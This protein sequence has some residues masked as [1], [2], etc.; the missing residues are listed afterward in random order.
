MRIKY[1]LNLRSYLA[2]NHPDKR[3]SDI[4]NFSR[5]I[6]RIRYLELSEEIHWFIERNT[7]LSIKK[8][9]NISTRKFSLVGTRQEKVGPALVPSA[10]SSIL[11]EF[12]LGLRLYIVL[13]CGYALGKWKDIMY[14]A[15]NEHLR[16]F[17]EKV[18]VLHQIYECFVLTCRSPWSLKCAFRYVFVR[19]NGSPSGTTSTFSN[20]ETLEV[21]MS[22]T[23]FCN[24]DDLKRKIT[25]SEA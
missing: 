4:T 3:P 10:S 22:D 16:S 1:H 11:D 8:G 15:E 23:I 9:A 24:Q 25:V 7:L 20:G 19:V 14:C 6:W 13:R 5:A 18:K 2:L 17:I 21:T 12:N